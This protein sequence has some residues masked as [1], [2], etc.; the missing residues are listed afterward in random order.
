MVPQWA[1]IINM[2]K[3]FTSCYHLAIILATI[4]SLLAKSYGSAPAGTKLRIVPS[5]KSALQTTINANFPFETPLQVEA[6]NEISENRL[7]LSLEITA[8]VTLKNG[9]TACLSTDSTFNLKAGVGTFLGSICEVPADTVT[10]KF[11]AANVKDSD[12]TPELTVKGD[13]YMS[14]MFS[15][16]WNIPAEVARWVQV[17]IDMYNDG[18]LDASTWEKPMPD[19]TIHLN[20]YYHEGTISGGLQA[21]AQM[22]AFEKANPE[23]KSHALFGMLDTKVSKMLL[24][25]AMKENYAVTSFQND[26]L[27]EFSDKAKFPRLNRLGASDG[28]KYQ[29]LGIFLRDRGWKKVVVIFDEQT[30][31][32]SEMKE[33]FAGLGVKIVKQYELLNEEVTKVNPKWKDETIYDHIF[34]DIKKLD[35]QIILNYA[36]GNAAMQLYGS[37]M[38]NL[39]TPR[40]NYQWI[41]I[42]NG[43]KRT[44]PSTN[45]GSPMC[46]QYG[47]L[48]DEKYPSECSTSDAK[49]CIVDTWCSYRFVGSIFLVEHGEYVNGGV[50]QEWILAQL[51]Y[52]D[53]KPVDTY[54]GLS[55]SFEN[56]LKDSY[57]V[58]LSAKAYDSAKFTVAVVKDLIDKKETVTGDKIASALRKKELS[59]LSS[60]NM[61][62]DKN[63]DYINYALES[64]I[65]Y[66]D[67][68]MK[69]GFHGDYNTWKVITLNDEKVRQ[70]EDWWFD[71][72]Y[73][74]ITKENDP[75]ISSRVHFFDGTDKTEMVAEVVT[76]ESQKGN[77]FARFKDKP[78]FE[79][80]FENI[81]NPQI[82]LSK[83]FKN[84]RTYKTY[85][86]CYYSKI[87]QNLREIVWNEWM[88]S[89]D[90]VKKELVQKEEFVAAQLF[91]L[92]GC[93]GNRT[94]DT[95]VTK[96]Q[97][98]ICIAKEQCQCAKDAKGNFKWTGAT[99]INPVCLNGC[100][101]GTCTEPGKCTCDKGWT[102]STCN[103]AICSDCAVAIGGECI[104]PDY[105]RCKSNYYG[106][107]CGSKCNCGANGD[108]NSGG[109]G[110]G[111]CTCHPGYMGE[112]CSTNW[113]LILGITLGVVIVGGLFFFF[114][115]WYLMKR[116]R[117]RSLLTNDDWIVKWSDVRKHDEKTGKSSMFL[118]ALS[119][120][121]NKAKK[122]VNTGSWN[123]MDVHYQRI[124]KD[125][126]PASMELRQEV[127][128]MREIHHVNVIT[129]VGICLDAPNVAILTE[130]APKGSLEDMLTNWDIKIPWDFRYPIMK[131]ICAGL[132]KIH[133]SDIQCHG[134]LKSANILIDGRWSPKI[135]GFGM[136]TLR[137]N[138]KHVGTFNPSRKNEIVDPSHGANYDSLIWTAPEILLLGYYHIDHV[139][140]GTREN[141]IYGL[142]YVFAEVCTRDLPFADLMIEKSEI[143]SL[144]KG[145]KN[146][147]SIKLWNDYIARQNM[148]A[149]VLIRPHIKDDQWPRKFEQRKALKKLIESCWHQDPD[150]RPSIRDC[151]SE[152]DRI[153]PQTT[154]I[155][156]RLVK[157]LERYSTNLEDVVTKRTKQLASEKAKAEDL[158]SRLLPKSVA[159]ELKLGKRV[160]A[161]TFEAVTI[162]FSDIVGF[163]TIARGSTPL[164]VVNLLNDMYTSFDAISENYD[165]YKVET[166]GDAYMIVSGLPIRNGDKHAGEITS[167]AMDLISS[168]GSFKIRHMPEKVMQLRV[169]LHTG[170]CVAGVV[171]IKM[172][173]YCLFGDTV[174]IAESMESGGGAMRIH[175]SEDTHAVLTRLGGYDMTFR[176]EVFVKNRGMVKTYWMNGKEG[177]RSM[178]TPPPM[179]ED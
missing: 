63:G 14:T 173:R 97:N 78:F 11:Q 19:R 162:F 5:S 142:G 135:S 161:E 110:D 36:Y 105:C 54:G 15:S 68:K 84:K 140:K 113:Y 141:D 33:R 44:F 25:L 125:S 80:H 95:D 69:W 45:Y 77:L 37:A 178:P 156:D 104:G 120:N 51:A 43:P 92:H 48:W 67:L 175:I 134:R 153:D 24:P 88:E 13:I 130:I 132:Q 87:D 16:Y 62:F 21:W 174:N 158:V 109:Q 71:A 3:M 157:M 93:G 38:R 9:G 35:T 138:Q 1:K 85:K 168:I 76:F 124:D 41:M 103:D 137:A 139:G 176:N 64:F 96:Y 86:D 144:I 118:S 65:L 75:L 82:Q 128:K 81:N 119:M 131:G 49:L 107:N 114:L 90:M 116:H 163:T 4:L 166:I 83:D 46:Y 179:D 115:S 167:C 66:P 22:K 31:P 100:I 29:A 47:K 7:D 102:G 23:K 165:C 101:H 28:Y 108:C 18:H 50:S 99:C 177:K 98:G 94:H 34:D 129:F 70:G 150:Q 89:P 169:G 126:V 6:V 59:G 172:P 72:V 106:A 112:T 123:G 52:K 79:S 159:D 146:E 148:E 133:E 151:I 143:I 136:E 74:P 127:I 8:V 171:G 145:W 40:D 55:F 30:R 42:G 27:K 111:L 160:E 10:I 73:G 26:G 58:S 147:E 170:S 164:Q 17:Y 91:C 20:N 155:M 121:Q 53:A 117:N 61:K 2:K 149:G 154:E 57:Y 60:A 56:K 39:A 12:E 122:A 152:I 32:T